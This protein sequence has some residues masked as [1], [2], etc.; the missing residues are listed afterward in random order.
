M[1]IPHLP[2]PDYQM[3]KIKLAKALVEHLLEI[4]LQNEKIIME[5]KRVNETCRRMEIALSYQSVK[6]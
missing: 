3:E 1:K 2:T 6:D 4:R 5:L